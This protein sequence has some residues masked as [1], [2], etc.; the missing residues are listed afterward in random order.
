MLLQLQH[1]KPREDRV[2]K[3]LCDYGFAYTFEAVMSKA[4]PPAST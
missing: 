2:Q 4:I 3:L 1:I